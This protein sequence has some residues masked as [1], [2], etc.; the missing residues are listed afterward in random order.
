MSKNTAPRLM[1]APRPAGAVTSALAQLQVTYGDASDTDSDSSSYED[2][3]SVCPDTNLGP[4]PVTGSDQTASVPGKSDLQK[5]ASGSSLPILPQKQSRGPH[6]LAQSGVEKT[7]VISSKQEVIQRNK[8]DLQSQLARITGKEPVKS[9]HSLSGNKIRCS[10]SEKNDGTLQMNPVPVEKLKSTLKD[11]NSRQTVDAGRV[12]VLPKRSSGQEEMKLNVNQQMQQK[13][14]VKRGHQIQQEPGIDPER[15]NQEV[16]D[17]QK[18]TKQSS[19]LRSSPIKTADAGSSTTKCPTTKSAS[20]EPG[21]VLQDCIKTQTAPRPWLLVPI[22]TEDSAGVSQG[23]NQ[24]QN[25]KLSDGPPSDPSLVS[26][27]QNT[28]S[29]QVPE[30]RRGFPKGMDKGRKKETGMPHGSSGLAVL[31]SKRKLGLPVFGHEAKKSF[32]SGKM[33]NHGD[34]TNSS[35]PGTTLE[36]EDSNTTLRS[37]DLAACRKKDNS[38]TSAEVLTSRQDVQ[39]PLPLPSTAGKDSQNVVVEGCI[40]STSSQS[41]EMMSPKVPKSALQ[42]AGS[43]VSPL[44]RKVLLEEPGAL[45]DTATTDRDQPETVQRDDEGT[46]QKAPVQLKE[47]QGKL[48][49]A[50][51]ENDSAK[52]PVA[53]QPAADTPGSASVSDDV[54]DNP[55]TSASQEGMETEKDAGIVDASSGEKDGKETGEAQCQEE[56]DNDDALSLGCDAEDLLET[57]DD[58]QE[59]ESAQPSKKRPGNDVMG[60]KSQAPILKL[61]PRSRQTSSSDHGQRSQSETEK[62]RTGGIQAV[63]PARPQDQRASHSSPPPT[64]QQRIP[65]RGPDDKSDAPPG[66]RVAP[67]PMN[68]D[69][70]CGDSRIG[71]KYQDHPRVPPDSSTSRQGPFGQA[72]NHPFQT[73]HVRSN[74]QQRLGN[75]VGPQ[76]P[77]A[78]EL[79]QT[80]RN[81]PSVGKEYLMRQLRHRQTLLQLQQML[82]SALQVQLGAVANHLDPR[83]KLS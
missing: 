17:Q 72:P 3:D 11:S 44:A 71:Q 60:S 61:L 20:K 75:R 5:V 27:F 29:H 8:A 36:L 66:R 26:R 7:T 4:G 2:D 34:A 69:F 39:L 6:P 50:L 22:T 38:S 57:L 18:S 12:K 52:V 62:G 13:E 79:Q 73:L 53:K 19:A 46:V 54:E 25:N 40:P 1:S 31:G 16:H 14:E 43:I 67:K 10:E 83:Y 80:M 70:R 77:Q 78:F 42:N 23:R 81:G 56:D 21:S 76:T 55:C 45:M 63:A 48:P 28:R 35:E 32:H 15:V 65:S 59:E 33:E 24:Q 37:S 64:S 47:T 41:D 74:L 30:D 49:G 58:N 68:R 9:E 82:P 51:L